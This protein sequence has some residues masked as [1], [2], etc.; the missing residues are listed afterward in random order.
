[1]EYTRNEILDLMYRSEAANLK[2]IADYIEKHRLDWEESA[3]L[4]R[5]ISDEQDAQSV[6]VRLR[7]DLNKPKI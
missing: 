5:E 4:I 2:T 7:D 6:V 3:Q 1:M